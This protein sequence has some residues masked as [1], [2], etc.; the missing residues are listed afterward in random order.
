MKSLRTFAILLLVCLACFETSAKSSEVSGPYANRLSQADVAAIKAVVSK[1]SH[2]SHNVKR[3]EAVRADKV[4]IQTTA[5]TAVDEDT[6][7]EFNVYK[8]AGAWTIDANSIQLSV[9]KR[10][11]RTNGPAIIR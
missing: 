9:E 2:V 3:I 6:V 5:R 4:T 8:R 7:Y 1:N 11:F 10:D